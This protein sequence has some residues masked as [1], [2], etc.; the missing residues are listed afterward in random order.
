VKKSE[1]V[2]VVV[3]SSFGGK[4]STGSFENSSPF[5][6]AQVELT[7]D[8]A[9]GEYVLGRI[10]TYQK[11]LQGLCQR[12]FKDVADRLTIERIEKDRKEIRFYLSPT[13]KKLPSVTSILNLGF[14]GYGI[15]GE[16]MS[17]YA[18][19]GNINH[20]RVH[21]FIKTEKWVAPKEL[22]ECWEDILTLK[23]GSL[24]LSPDAC[25]FPAFLEKYPMEKLKNSESV[26]NEEHGY[27][28]TPDFTAVPIFK[29]ADPVESVCDV[30]RS[31]DK[32]K[33][34]MQMAAYAK[35]LGLKQMV[36]VPLNDDTAQGFSKPIVSS[37]VDGYF[38]M[39]LRKLVKFKK[40]YGL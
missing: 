22:Q 11:D 31:I 20:A 14:T 17:E 23:N 6:S 1:L 16:D 4:I 24:A 8:R 39:F 30:K 10:D 12:Q 35:C 38:E 15:S 21:H 25:N 29:G 28:G 9:D 33:N 36:I 40:Q 37:D 32:V 5:F 7:L 34:F 13:G 19:Q 27:A 3:S 26:F 2:K 18:S